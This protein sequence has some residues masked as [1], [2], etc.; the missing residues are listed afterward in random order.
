MSDGASNMPQEGDVCMP[1]APAAKHCMRNN[2]VLSS[3]QERP[4]KKENKELF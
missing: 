4:L 2:A 3:I 1:E